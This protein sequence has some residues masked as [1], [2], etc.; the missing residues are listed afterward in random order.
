M[1]GQLCYL[2]FPIAPSPRE[3]S[4]GHDFE[5]RCQGCDLPFALVLVLPLP[6]GL[7]PLADGPLCLGIRESRLTQDVVLFGQFTPWRAP[8]SC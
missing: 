3:V 8:G 2:F 4:P 1:A 7:A 5:L 6:R